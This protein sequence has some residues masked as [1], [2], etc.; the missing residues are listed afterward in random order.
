VGK[1]LKTPETNQTKVFRRIVQ[2]LKNDPTVKR[3]V[4]PNL[5]SWEG[6][7]ADKSPFAPS[8]NAPVVRLTPNPVDEDWYSP[9]AAVE[10]L[11]VK[12]ELGISSTCVDD[13]TDLWGVLRSALLPNGPSVGGGTSFG[14]DLAAVGAETGEI[15]FGAPGIAPRPEASPEG[16]MYGEGRFYLR[17]VNTV[18]PT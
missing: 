3:L 2:Q 1:S 13:V 15:V 17:I 7:T 10:T 4:G 8:A 16:T 14:L 11:W 18:Q 9:D 6:V 12:V 5:R